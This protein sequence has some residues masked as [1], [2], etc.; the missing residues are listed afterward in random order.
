MIT[1]ASLRMLLDLGL[2]ARF[3]VVVA[4]HADHRNLHRGNLA[5]ERL[6]FFGQPVV[7]QVPAQHQ[8]VGGIADLREQRLQ[9]PGD[10]VAAVVKIADRGDPDDVLRS[11]HTPPGQHSVSEQQEK[12][13]SGR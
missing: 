13:R 7:G 10:G 5:G 3:E 11:G 8:H 1:P 2:L 12:C 4:E 6:G 9:R